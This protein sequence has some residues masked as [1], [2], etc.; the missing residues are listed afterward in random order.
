[1]EVKYEEEDL[2]LMLVCLLPNSYATFRD[3]I[4]YSRDTLTLN[5]VYQSLL[6][7][8]KMKRLIVGPQ[9][10]EDSLFVRGRPQ[11]KNYGEEQRKRSKSRNSNKICKYCKKKGYIKK[12]CFKLHDKEKKFENKQGE[13]SR[14]SSEASVVESDQ[15]DGELLVA[16]DVDSRASE[17]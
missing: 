17:N 2:G 13:K 1:M 5:E 14:K 7:K 16:S 10:H 12:E 3:T 11:E 9:A 15:T 8:E 6:S 4:L